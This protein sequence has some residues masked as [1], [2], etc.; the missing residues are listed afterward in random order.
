MVAIVILGA[1]VGLL[2]AAFGIYRAVQAGQVLGSVELG[3]VALRG[4]TEVEA[5]EA[6]AE[7]EQLLL[8]TN[9]RFIVEGQQV[10]LEGSEVDL[11][12]DQD[13]LVREAM[14]VGREGNLFTQIGWFFSN[15]FAEHRLT[16][17]A[18]INETALEAV[19]IEWQTEAGIEPPFEGAIAIDGTKVEPLYPVA[20]RQIDRT[21]ARNLVTEELKEPDQVTTLLPVIEASPLLDD[22]DIDLVVAEAELMLS[23]PIVLTGTGDEEDEELLTTTFETDELASALRSRF[24][25]PPDPRIELFFDVAVIEGLLIPLLEELEAPPV[26]ARFRIKDEKVTVIPGKNGTLLSATQVTAQLEIAARGSAREGLLP[27]EVGAEPD[28]TTAELE[29]LNITHLVSRFTTHHDCCPPRVKNIHLFADEVD[30]A[31]VEP[32]AELS[33]NVLVGRRTEKEGYVKAPTIVRG[34]LV[35]TVGGG[36]SQFATT[37]Y[38]AVFWGGYEDISHKPH[39]FYITRYPEGVEATIS[40]PEPHLIFRNNRDSGILI[41]TSYT[42][43]SI[44]VSFYG[45][46]DG[47]TVNGSHRNGETSINVTKKGGDAAR[48]IKLTRSDRYNEKKAPKT[49]YRANPDLEVDEEKRIQGSMDGWSVKVTRKI[50]YGNGTPEEVDGWV[51]IYQPEQEII[52]V[53]PCK[54]PGSSVTCPTTT[55]EPPPTTT[56]TT[57]VPPTTT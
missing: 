10:F 11:N 57:S 15:V 37:F 54:V 30:G 1:A 25:G 42:D 27:F 40:W 56:T 13:S 45:N 48:R 19:L 49:K 23:A 31:L 6:V 3:D 46:N 43:T 7:Y 20:G 17:E 28:R 51:V 16:P 35:D 53:H 33:L 2:I 8:S 34:L 12:I 44:T 21:A 9:G 18:T 5:I 38:N 55:T 50:T 4:M 39:S 36:V 22:T 52:E 24:V 26:N 47:R 41:K 32:G 14:A 29:A